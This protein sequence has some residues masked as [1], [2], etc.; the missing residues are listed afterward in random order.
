MTLEQESW[1]SGSTAI[2]VRHKAVGLLAQD[3]GHIRFQYTDSWLANPQ[4]FALGPDLPLSVQVFFAPSETEVFGALRDTCPDRWGQPILT[5]WEARQARD[6]QRSTSGREL[7]GWESLAAK[8]S[9][10]FA[11]A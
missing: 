11:C 6:E 9:A 7:V 8:V 5:R 1:R 3:H 4:A 10:R 2:S